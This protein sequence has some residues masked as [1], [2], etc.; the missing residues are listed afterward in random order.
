MSL[1]N[2]RSLSGRIGRPV[3]ATV[4]TVIVLA[5]SVLVASVLVAGPVNADPESAESTTTA[6]TTETTTTPPT[7]ASGSTPAPLTGS[8]SGSP[9]GSGSGSPP[10]SASSET[11]VPATEGI[12]NLKVIDL[13]TGA[14]VVGVPA[15][16][17]RPEIHDTTMPASILL[18]AG[19]Y[20]VEILGIPGGYRLVSSWAANPVVPADGAVDVV[21]ELTSQQK[22]RGRVPIRSI[23]S[24]RI[25]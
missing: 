16:V 6:V 8:G 19:H 2:G 4:S 23:P 25:S 7:S 22:N 1:R 20:R 14:E 9:S 24:G 12:L 11:T 13:A 17:W 15:R 21:F 10:S 5:A 3:L 18:P